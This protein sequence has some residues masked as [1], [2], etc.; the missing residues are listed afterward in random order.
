LD[1][2]D[3]KPQDY[4]VEMV[5]Q[6]GT[7]IPGK[8]LDEAGLRSMKGL[9]LSQIKRRGRILDQPEGMEKLEGDDVLTFM[10]TREGLLELT[11]I[12]GL[13]PLSENS[14][15]PEG[16]GEKGVFFSHLAEAVVSEAFPGLG[17]S[18]ENLSFRAH[19]DSE[20]LAVHRNGVKLTGHLG[21]IR[22]R[23]GDTLVL[24]TRDYRS[25]KGR[26]RDFYFVNTLGDRR[27]EKPL[28]PWGILLALG[29]MV[30]GGVFGPWI[31]SLL[32]INLGFFHFSLLGVLILL[33]SRTLGWRDLGKGVNMPLLF[34]LGSALSLGFALE[35][36]GFIPALM[37]IVSPW[38]E[39]LGLHGAVFIFLLITMLLTETVTN[40]A[41]AALM[42]PFGWSLAQST[43]MDPLPLFMAIAIGA[44]ASFL[45]PMG[46]QTNLVIQGIGGYKSADYFRSGIFLSLLI[47]T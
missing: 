19:Y 29:V 42:L 35:T 25:L 10:G 26:T 36:T 34:T 6:Q 18:I 5:V 21:S 15:G 17:L 46:Y 7:A 11:Q 3:E 22:L 9:M 14:L 37:E 2:L 16:V 38:I 13:S 24:A 27:P 39:G 45:T 28:A 33:F 32:P 40:N 12:P 1:Q 31:S 20:V 44:S 8:T 4:L 41:A 43:G 23:A 30:L 47:L